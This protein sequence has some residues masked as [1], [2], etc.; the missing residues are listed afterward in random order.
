MISLVWLGRLNGEVSDII[1]VLVGMLLLIVSVWKLLLLVRVV[2]VIIIEF[3]LFYSS[4]CSMLVVDIG[5]LCRIRLLLCDSVIQCVVGGWLFLFL[6]CQVVYRLCCCLI[7][8]N[9]MFSVCCRCL[10]V[11]FFGLFLVICVCVVWV[12]LNSVWVLLVSV[13][14]LV[15]QMFGRCLFGVCYIGF[16]V[17]GLG[18]QLCLIILWKVLSCLLMCVVILIVLLGSRLFSLFL[19]MVWQV[20]VIMICSWLVCLVIL[21]IVRLV[22]F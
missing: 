13:L 2:E 19:F 20:V 21:F 1:F 15:I 5:E 10:C 4:L 9:V 12:Q 14:M 7:I 18:C 17:D 3:I 6:W 22:V 8:F 11:V 16:C